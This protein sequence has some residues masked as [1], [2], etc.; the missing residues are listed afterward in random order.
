MKAKETNMSKAMLRIITQDGE[1]VSESNFD[2]EYSACETMSEVN[3]RNVIAQVL[4]DDNVYAEE[5]L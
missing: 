1:I 2:D 4:L 5:T 3:V